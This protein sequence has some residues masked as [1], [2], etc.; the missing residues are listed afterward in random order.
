MLVRRAV[1]IDD[2]QAVLSTIVE[3]T[4]LLGLEVKGFL[5]PAAALAYIRANRVD[6]ILTD[7]RMP[8]MD[9]VELVREVRKIDGDVPIVMITGNAEDEELRRRA[10]S[11]GVTDIL[12]KPIDC[13]RFDAIIRTIMK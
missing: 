8:G 5:C 2:E 6:L 7:F 3:L 4:A 12:G 13:R 1:A 9:G 11:S 10:W